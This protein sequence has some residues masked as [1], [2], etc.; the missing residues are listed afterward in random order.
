MQ[1]AGGYNII[2]WIVGSCRSINN[3]WTVK[4]INGSMLGHNVKLNIVRVLSRTHCM[5]APTK[6]CSALA[7]EVTQVSP[8]PVKIYWVLFFSRT[9]IL[10]NQVIN[11]NLPNGGQMSKL[12]LWTF[13]FSLGLVSVE[14]EEGRFHGGLYYNNQHPFRHKS[15]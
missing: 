11:I 7:S 3:C 8:C 15:Q 12:W 6:V 14:A 4:Y 13:L 10:C 2:W 1:P 5:T 9:L